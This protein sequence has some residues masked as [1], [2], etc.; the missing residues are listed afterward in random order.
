[1]QT[2]LREAAIKGC[3]RAA[4]L[5]RRALLRACVWH[6]I[7]LEFMHHMFVCWCSMEPE[8]GHN[9]SLLLNCVEGFQRFN[10]LPR[11]DRK[12]RAPIFLHNQ[13]ALVLSVHPTL[14]LPSSGKVC[15]SGT[16]GV[17]SKMKMG[18]LGAGVLFSSSLREDLWDEVA[19]IAGNFEKEVG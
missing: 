17:I 13:G 10:S 7:P 1:M 4:S 15:T 12:R 2:L 9:G 16:P 14:L 6:G 11:G 5:Q 19:L 3:L 18:Q 8:G